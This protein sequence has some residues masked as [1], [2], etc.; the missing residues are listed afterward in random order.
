[1]RAP[2]TPSSLTWL[3]NRHARLQG[4]LIKLDKRADSEISALDA[5]RTNLATQERRIASAHL[6]KAAWQTELEALQLLLSRH[7]IPISA[8]LISPVRERENVA[9]A[10][11]GQI[12]SSIFEAVSKLQS[13]A[14]STTEV[15]CH[16]QI[17]LGLD[18]DQSEFAKFRDRIRQ[19]LKHLAWEGRLIRVG[20]KG[21]YLEQRWSL[22][23]RSH[24]SIS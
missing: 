10:K 21:R 17:C 12:T 3:I 14:P 8:D 22:P 18:F 2:P 6:C 20:N 23:D 13:G 15:A 24:L 19:R 7:E 4:E 5:M 1:M 11:H 16:V 9:I